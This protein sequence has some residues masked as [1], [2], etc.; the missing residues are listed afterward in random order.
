MLFLNFFFPYASQA[1]QSYNKM[2]ISIIG[3]NCLC[4]N[5]IVIA[6]RKTGKADN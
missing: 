5:I 3:V 6:S 2:A 4:E 1:H